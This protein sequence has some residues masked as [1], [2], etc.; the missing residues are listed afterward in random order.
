MIEKLEQDSV[1]KKRFGTESFNL[2]LAELRAAFAERTLADAPDAPDAPWAK[3]SMGSA[4]KLAE[5]VA[6]HSALLGPKLY[7]FGYDPRTHRE[8]RKRFDQLAEGQPAVPAA[9]KS[10]LPSTPR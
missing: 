5:A 1:K 8:A 2:G 7:E 10:S 9:S 6:R 4:S 3:K